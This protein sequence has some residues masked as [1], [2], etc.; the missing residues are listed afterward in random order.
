MRIKAE[1]SAEVPEAFGFVSSLSLLER[2]RWLLSLLFRFEA[3]FSFV[4]CFFLSSTLS[5]PERS[6]E[7]DLSL[8][9]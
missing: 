3:F 9:R 6:L 4:E 2:V 7:E 8:R 5:F 1:G